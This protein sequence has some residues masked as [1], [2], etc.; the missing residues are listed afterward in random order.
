MPALITGMVG[1]FGRSAAALDPP[2]AFFY[3][4]TFHCRPGDP[5]RGLLLPR[6]AGIG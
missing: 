3:V 2:I 6:I 5:M 4:T 1:A